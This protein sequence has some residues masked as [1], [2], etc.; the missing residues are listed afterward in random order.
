[1]ARLTQVQLAGA[2]GIQQ[3]YLS[4]IEARLR[5]GSAQTLA[6]LALALDVPVGWLG[7]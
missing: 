7:A 6:A 1:M 3:G 4:D 2:A 5:H